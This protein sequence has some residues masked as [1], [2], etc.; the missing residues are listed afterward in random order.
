MTSWKEVLAIP[1]DGQTGAARDAL[2]SRGFDFA[3]CVSEGDVIGIV[4]MVKLQSAN[5][6]DKSRNVMRPLRISDLVESEA[7]IEDGGL[8]RRNTRHP[9]SH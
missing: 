5:P 9:G 3:P 1:G 2:A 7:P 4:D 8:A 6:E